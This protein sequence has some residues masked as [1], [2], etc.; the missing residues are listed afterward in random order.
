[1]LPRFRACHGGFEEASVCGG[2][3]SSLRVKTKMT[4]I[5]FASAL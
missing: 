2:K 5:G 4:D 1:M 3:S